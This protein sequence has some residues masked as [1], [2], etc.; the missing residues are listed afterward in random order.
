MKLFNNRLLLTPIDEEKQ[1]EG[2]KDES[3]K[4]GK[5]AFPFSGKSEDEEIELNEG[6]EIYYQYGTNVHIGGQ[7]YILVRLSEIVCLK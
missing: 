1:W 4:L 3:V 2:L 5:L 7:D 6:D